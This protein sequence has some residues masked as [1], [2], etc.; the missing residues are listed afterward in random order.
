MAFIVLMVLGAVLAL[1]LVDSR[2]VE[3]A[4]GSRV[5]VMKS[6]SWRT[7]IVGLFEC[8][9]QDYYIIAL[10]PMFMASNWFYTYQVSPTWLIK[11]DYLLGYT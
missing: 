8:L 7:E 2:N 5:I 9:R 3:R 6:P 1:F 11:R 4:D 10:F